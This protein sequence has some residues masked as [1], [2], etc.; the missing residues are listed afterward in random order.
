[1]NSPTSKGS[2]MHNSNATK[3]PPSLLT[4]KL[5]AAK[6]PTFTKSILRSSVFYRTENGFDRCIVRIDQNY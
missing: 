1:M 6:H 5:F 4:V 3:Q 2:F